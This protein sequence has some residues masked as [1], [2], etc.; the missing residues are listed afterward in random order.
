MF[1]RI[2]IG[3][4]CLFNSKTVFFFFHL[5]SWKTCFLITYFDQNGDISLN[6]GPEWAIHMSC[7][8]YTI[9][10]ATETWSQRWIRSV[11]QR[12]LCAIHRK[13]DFRDFSADIASEIRPDGRDPLVGWCWSIVKSCD[14]NRCWRNFWLNGKIPKN[15]NV[16]FWTVAP[17]SS[18][19]G[20]FWD[21]EELTLALQQVLLLTFTLYNKSFFA[22][23]C[24]SVHILQRTLRCGGTKYKNTD[25][26]LHRSS[27]H[28]RTNTDYA[29]EVPG[30]PV[31]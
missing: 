1:G 8:W 25:M 15:K 23:W 2:P 21:P 28:L 11:G 17:L 5:K 29:G 6:I 26:L 31:K 4:S 3:M 18:L 27:F 16:R 7:H 9:K 20:A 10:Y 13:P 24:I 30:C 22:T 19:I 14:L 12:E